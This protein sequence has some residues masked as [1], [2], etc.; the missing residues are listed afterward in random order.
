MMGAKLA[1]TSGRRSARWA[2]MERFTLTHPDTGVIYLHGLRIIATPLFGLF[3]HRLGCPDPGEDLH[4]HPWW[5]AS[6]VLRGGYTETVADTRSA[7]FFARM[8]VEMPTCK[9]GE[10]RSW[11]AGTIHRIRL[12]ECHRITA[13]RREPTWTLILTGPRARSWGFYPPEGF[14]DFR[15]YE[16]AA[17]P[18]VAKGKIPS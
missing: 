2:F 5:F 15:K 12:T 13:L 9:R 18:L 6:L 14:V 7:P 8:A 4:D 11:R 1:K 17:R 16:R 3:L 10:E